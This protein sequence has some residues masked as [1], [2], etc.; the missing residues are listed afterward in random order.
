MP[1]GEKLPNVLP[2]ETKPGEI[3]ADTRLALELA[4][5]PRVDVKNSE[6][7]RERCELYFRFCMENDIRPSV[8]GLTLSL[9]T[10]RQSLINWEQE[11]G[12]RGEVIREA[13]GVIRYLLETWSLS[14]KLSPPTAIFWA[15]NLLN[16]T[17]SVKIEAV[18]NTGMLQAEKSPEQI[19]A[20]IPL[21]DEE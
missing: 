7:I 4:R 2:I 6:Q 1:K 8:S 19:I 13:K 10:N 9:N 5:L 15:K 16:M 12:E 14:G 17:D 18:N 20:E 21:D 3:S 11:P